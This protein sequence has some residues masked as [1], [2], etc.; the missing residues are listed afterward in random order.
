MAALSAVRWEPGSNAT[1]TRH[2]Q[3]GNPHGVAVLAVMREQVC[4]L[5]ALLPDDR[6]WQPECAHR[7]LVAAT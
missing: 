2:P 4:P 5:N 3:L 1:Y 7:P 6:S